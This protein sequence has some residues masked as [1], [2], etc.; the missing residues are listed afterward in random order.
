MET[1]MVNPH[2]CQYIQSRV[3]LNDDIVQEY[4]DMFIEDMAPQFD[5]CKGVISDSGVMI[6]YDG[7]HRGEAAKQV[8][9]FIAV[10]LSPGTEH[11]AEW[12]AAGANTRHGL[13]RSPIDIEKSVKSALRHPNAQGKSDREIARHCG[14]DHKTVGKYRKDLEASGE[15]PQMPTRTVQRNGTEYQMTVP[16]PPE[17]EPEPESTRNPS[18]V[19][20]DEHM[21][22]APPMTDVVDCVQCGKL[23]C[24]DVKKWKS[25][26]SIYP[27]V[28][29]I[30]R[31]CGTRWI[32][33]SSY[34]AQR[35]FGTFR[36][37]ECEYYSK[38]G[39][40][41]LRGMALGLGKNCLIFTA[42]EKGLDSPST[43]P[44]VEDHGNTFMTVKC[45]D[46]GEEFMRP[47]DRPDLQFCLD[48]QQARRRERERPPE[49]EQALCMACNTRFP[50]PENRP[51]L[52]Y[53]LCDS[54][55]ADHDRE[56][57][58]LNRVHQQHGLIPIPTPEPEP[59]ANTVP[60]V[61]DW[62]EVENC[63]FCGREYLE[64]DLYQGKNDTTVVDFY[65]CLS[66][67]ERAY[68]EL[69]RMQALGQ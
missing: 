24:V 69:L 22:D 21:P 48:C 13:R 34:E 39:R 55:K 36:C 17:P 10:E 6:I 57:A 67:S 30:C 42:A 31:Q 7:N 65:I 58:E 23:A 46:C 50:Q 18:P 44:G 25:K 1:R 29:I 41:C 43:V 40:H 14:C 63:D 3:S 47:V 4:A 62:D 2:D 16:M 60:G 9:C 5:P 64:D 59:E 19:V 45:L 26:S 56:C 11:D 66:C 61:N 32:T 52:K 12:L 37:C 28:D 68:R 53:G 38:A 20:S 27:S 8:G 49:P 15:R 51:D 35:E 54:C 33:W